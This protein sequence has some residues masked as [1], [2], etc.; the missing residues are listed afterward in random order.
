MADQT[1]QAT[2]GQ[3]PSEVDFRVQG[4]AQLDALL[5]STPEASDQVVEIIGRRLATI[6]SHTSSDLFNGL[7]ALI[8][9]AGAQLLLSSSV[10][11]GQLDSLAD[12]SPQIRQL[13]GRTVALYG[14]ELQA[15]LDARELPDDWKE[16]NREV[17]SDAISGGYLVRVRIVKYNG[18]VALIE[19]SPTSMLSLAKSMLT[20]LRW[21]AA[22]DAFAADGV[23][24]FVEEAN[25][26]LTM[27]QPPPTPPATNGGTHE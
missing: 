10:G 7:K 12:A 20:T 16:F 22:P 25:A 4:L 5:S 2:D 14:P 18:D 8:G 3:A 19:G 17:F 24:P 9:E 27:L 1:A 13:V 23:G 26:V 11:E 21:I 6:R 15:S